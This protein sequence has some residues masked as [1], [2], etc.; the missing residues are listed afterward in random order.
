VTPVKEVIHDLASSISS[1]GT[2]SPI[3]RK[4][5]KTCVTKLYKTDS[6]MSESDITT[7]ETDEFT[8]E[9]DCGDDVDCI[10]QPLHPNDFVV[11][12]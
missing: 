4:K 8:A 10:T 2:P 11:L 3:L 12:N 5:V 6:E 7:H 1:S 9:G